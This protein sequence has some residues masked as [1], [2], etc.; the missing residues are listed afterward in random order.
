MQNIFRGRIFLR[1]AH[2]YRG[3]TLHRCSELWNF[4]D[5]IGGNAR[6]TRSSRYSTKVMR[7][8]QKMD[9]GV[10]SRA[11]KSRKTGKQFEQDAAAVVTRIVVFL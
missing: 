1:C 3:G 9:V 8:S 11:L 2:F 4:S 10:H 6:Y 5:A 7:M